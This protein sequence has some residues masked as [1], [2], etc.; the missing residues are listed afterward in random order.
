MSGEKKIEQL[1]ILGID[2]AKKMI[3]SH[4]NVIPFAVRVF[5]DSEEVTLS[6][7]YDEFS[8]DDWLDLI[9]HTTEKLKP[10]VKKGDIHAVGIFTTL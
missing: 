1:I 4:G 6:S 8:G 9:H 5:V 3:S 10:I 2:A 7:Y